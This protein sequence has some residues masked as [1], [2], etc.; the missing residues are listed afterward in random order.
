[1]S[2]TLNAPF[3]LKVDP[4]NGGSP[5]LTM[6]YE[7][8]PPGQGIPPHHHPLADEI[9]FVHRGSGTASLGPRTAPVT[10]GT[11]I[12]IPRNTRISL[13]N[14]GTEPLSIAYIFSR[15]GFE[16]YLRETSVPEGQ[17]AAPL[18]PEEL[19]RI[20]SRHPDHVVYEAGGALH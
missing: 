7:D 14:T 3:I 5:D 19:A 2:R 12:Y 13:Q 17:Q 9:L 8:I 18:S 6:G 1:M 16:D 20:R 11:T 10:T 4:K 15:P